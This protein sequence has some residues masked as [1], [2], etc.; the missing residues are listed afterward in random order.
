MEK[1]SALPAVGG[2]LCLGSEAD[3]D[4]HGLGDDAAAAP[5]ARRYASQFPDDIAPDEAVD[6]RGVRSAWAHRRDVPRAHCAAFPLVLHAVSHSSDTLQKVR[7]RGY[8]VWL[9]VRSGKTLYQ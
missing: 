3:C 4:A 1:A 9:D 8:A 6:E 7:G 2:A 5:S